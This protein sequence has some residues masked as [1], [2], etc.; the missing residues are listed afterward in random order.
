MC[1]FFFIKKKTS[2]KLSFE[3]LNYSSNLLRHRGPDGSKIYQDKDIFVKFFRLS[4]QDLSE[5][6][7]QPMISLS[8]KN[9]IVFNGEIYNF[10]ILQKT[11]AKKLRSSSDTEVL[12]ELYEQIGTNIF[13]YIKGMFS[14]IIYNFE[15]KKI[16]VARDQFGI[17]PLY[18]HDCK[19]HVIFCSEIK[20]ILNFINKKEI[21]NNSLAEFFFLGKQ[22]H[23]SNSFFNSIK[24]IEPAHYYKFSNNKIEKKKYWSIFCRNQKK[25]SEEIT[26]EKLNQKL[27]GTINDYLISDKKIG[28]FMSSGVDSTSLASI[29]SKKLNYKLDT[30]TYDFNNNYGFGESQFAKINSKKIGTKNNIAILNSKEVIMNFDNMCQIL[31]SPFTSIRLFAVHKL[32]EMAKLK[33]YNVI[34]EGA[35]G[36]EILGG[37]SYNYLPY[38]LD[39]NKYLNNI[40]NDL[41]DFSIASKKKTEIELI[42]RLITLTFQGGSTTDATPFIDINFFNKNFLNNFLDDS[43]YNLDKSKFKNFLDMNKLQR[44]QILD[45][46]EIKLPRNLKYT[47]RLSMSNGIET[48]LPFLDVD[49]AKFCFN[50]KNDFKIKPNENRWIMKKVLKKMKKNLNFSKNK[51]TIADPQSNWLKTDLKEYFMDNIKSKNFKNIEIFDQKYVSDKFEKFIKDEHTE[52]SFQFF[53]ILSSYR[54]IENFK[55]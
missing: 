46:Q 7:M 52:S 12:L 15:T 11:L 25:D 41:L 13:D 22:D 6:A 50:L 17:K 34:I 3:K 24:S 2:K 51:R 37:Y 31:E 55:N 1:G 4:I 21:N 28:V 10:K 40:I 47:D 20:P 48:R 30:F 9:I 33:S 29:I 42:N 19:D 27:Q 38:L 16:L 8:K 18:F 14:F 54:F 26:I 43:F 35:G 23:G 45:I 44:S 32:Y 39:K 49:I 5:K 36:D 53:Q